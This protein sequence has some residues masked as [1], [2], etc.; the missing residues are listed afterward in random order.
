MTNKKIGF[1]GLGRMGLPMS[2]N[3]LNAGYD[4]TVHNRSQPKVQEIAAKGATVAA[5]TA[6]IT[7]ECDILLACLPDIATSEEIFL[8]EDGVIAN[9]RAGQ[10]LV[11]HS[12][13]GISTSKAC[14]EA[15]EAKGAMFLD[16]PISGGT[17]RAENATLV[18]MA[19]GPKEAYDS[20]SEIFDT[21]GGTV[22]HTGPTGTG[23]T[24][25][26]VNQLLVGIH[27]LA[28]AEAMLM[29]A[30]SGAD[31]ALVYELVSSGWGQSFMLDRNAPVMIDQT[32]EDARAPVR[33][34]L[35]DLGL[36]QELAQSIGTPIPAGDVAYAAFTKAAEA[37]LGELDV[38][39][40]V[41][42][43]EKEAGVEVK[44]KSSA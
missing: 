15:A 40:V 21:M 27:S 26:L 14:A 23:T 5:S 13:V 41:K 11:D 44:R 35:K 31:P 30:K 16:A 33:L 36:I 19:G 4:L 39:A 12:T 24:V 10:I 6:E 42:L 22:R 3:L 43:L 20:V 1:I 17:E 38:P 32:Y 28:A 2:Y 25:K 8:G 18:I 34:I 29:G 37:G 9:A 7:R